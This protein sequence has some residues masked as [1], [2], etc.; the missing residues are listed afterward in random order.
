MSKRREYTVVHKNLNLAVGG[1]LQKQVVGSTLSMD[2]ERA[3]KM[4]KKGWIVDP[5]KSKKVVVGSTQE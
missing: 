5:S 1:K 3:K 2:S 4:L